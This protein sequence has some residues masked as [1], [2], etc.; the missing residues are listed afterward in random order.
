MVNRVCIMEVAVFRVT[1]MSL[2]LLFFGCTS[3]TFT[4]LGNGTAVPSTSIDE[5]AAENGLTRA[6]ARAQMKQEYDQRRI[7]EYAEKYGISPEE[8]K[9]QLEHADEISAPIP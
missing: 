8:A 9:A 2:V 4:D 6:Q 3:P 5:H 7:A 1:L